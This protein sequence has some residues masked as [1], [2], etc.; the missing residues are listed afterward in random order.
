MK[1]A[2][3]DM[4]HSAGHTSTQFLVIQSEKYMKQNYYSNLPPNILQTSS[5]LIFCGRLL[6]KS[7]IVV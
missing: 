6:H 4:Q 2:R 3:Q 1:V 7:L 5:D